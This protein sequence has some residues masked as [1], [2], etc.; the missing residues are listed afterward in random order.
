MLPTVFRGTQVN[1]IICV[2]Y[3]RVLCS[4]I[5]TLVFVTRTLLSYCAGAVFSVSLHP[6]GEL[7]CSGGEDDKAFVWRVTDGTVVFECQGRQWLGTD[8]TRSLSYCF[9][10]GH[11]D[12]VTCMGFSHD[13]KY[14][15][16][17]DMGGLIQVW[18]VSSGKLLWSFETSDIEVDIG[19]ATLPSVT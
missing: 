3:I 5:C 6:S 1:A 10:P 18:L 13:G 9:H 12:S 4:D 15:A 2:G 8:E 11:K 14:V 7:A 19:P 17:A 16:T